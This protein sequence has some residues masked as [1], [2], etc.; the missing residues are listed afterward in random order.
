VLIMDEP[1]SALAVA[2]VEAVLRLIGR[3]KER[4]V[5]VILI[6]HRLQDLFRVCDRIA[7]L[8]EGRNVAER[9]IG[10][11]NLED[12]VGLIVGQRLERVRAGGP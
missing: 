11:T 8:Y 6:T 7:V 12:I 1:T 3:V 2:E 10:E 5:G 9:R 4:G